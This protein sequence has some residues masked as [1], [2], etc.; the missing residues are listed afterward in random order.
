MVSDFD[1]VA[2][3]RLVPIGADRSDCFEGLLGT[4]PAMRALFEDI[5]RIA[6]T[7]LTVLVQG[8]TGSG[9]D[10]VADAIHRAST[11]RDKPY[12]VFDCGAVAPSLA[13]SELFGHERGAFTGAHVSRPGVFELA[14]H[15]TLFLD[16][17]GE[18]PK[19]LQ[20]KL[21]RALE[22]R[23]IRRVG[24]LKTIQ[25][26]VRIVAAT[27]R[28]LPAEVAR[29]TFRQDLYFRVAAAQLTVP[30][31]RDRV[32]D[33]PLL[34]RHFLSRE[35]PPR[36]ID[37]LPPNAWQKLC[38]HA[39]PGNVRELRNVVQR[40]LVTPERALKRLTAVA[41]PRE[42]N[43]TYGEDPIV[44]LQESRAAANRRF[45]L[46]YLRKILARTQGHITR[47]AAIAQVSR[48]VM[49]KLVRKHAA[50]L[51]TL[52]ASGARISRVPANEPTP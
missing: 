42:N 3:A 6:S 46:E 49:T 29:G 52:T 47:A 12:V 26:D 36:T 32:E 34:V 8:E 19:D 31:L 40:M 39:W 22:K 33:I 51:A 4:S 28:D 1:N 11:R 50:D 2:T 10:V 21:L 38:E 7:D 45:E 5:E 37:A 25:V 27:N 41:D 13:E 17:L 23:E 9:K 30:A 15:G 24:G 35:S 16:E 20:P 44:P 43:V 18:L 48:Q 14:Q